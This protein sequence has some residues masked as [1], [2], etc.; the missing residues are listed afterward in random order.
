MNTKESIKIAKK[1]LNFYGFYTPF[2]IRMFG[3]RDTPAIGEHWQE[4]DSQL[5]E[6]DRIL[7]KMYPEYRHILVERHLN[8]LSFDDQV[9]KYGY[10]HSQLSNYIKSAYIDFMDKAE[11]KKPDKPVQNPSKRLIKTINKQYI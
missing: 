2:Y 7:D 10:A 11:I 9:S 8:M 3:S 5:K 6:V 4:R 1:Y